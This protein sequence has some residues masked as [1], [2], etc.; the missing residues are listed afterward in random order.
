[1]GWLRGFEPPHDGI[2][3]HCLNRLTTATTDLEQVRAAVNEELCHSQ[4]DTPKAARRHPRLQ[5]WLHALERVGCL[6][7]TDLPG[8]VT[9]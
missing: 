3:I 9:L 7:F 4:V 1:M 8:S 6:L 2:T 5:V